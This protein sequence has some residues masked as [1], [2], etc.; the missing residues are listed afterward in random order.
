MRRKILFVLVVLSFVVVIPMSFASVEKTNAASFAAR[1]NGKDL[2]AQ[3]CARC[4]GA[5]GRG[6]TTLGKTFKAPDLTNPAIHRR[7][8]ARFTRSIKNG[9]GNMPAF[10]RKLSAQDIIALIAYVRSLKR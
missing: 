7:S 10:S 5:D 8:D 4:H 9:R 1:Q 6:K 2:Y 3:H